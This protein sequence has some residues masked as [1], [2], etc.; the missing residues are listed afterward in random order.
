[1]LKFPD[2]QVNARQL[3]EELAAL[4]LPGFVG[5]AQLS[6]EIDEQGRVVLEDGASKRVPPYIL[7][8]SN[9]LTNLQIAAVTRI[10]TDHIPGI[11]LPPDP[12]FEEQAKACEM[13][14]TLDEL[15]A[16]LA[17]LVRAL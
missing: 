2:K 10:I 4:S 9:E 8:K 12:R 3:N 15:K 5:V 11:D 7:V 1:M 13:A 14:T 16:V 17:Q 6:R